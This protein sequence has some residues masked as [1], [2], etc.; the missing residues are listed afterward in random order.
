[1]GRKA[2]SGYHP[3]GCDTLMASAQSIPIISF[4][5]ASWTVP[6]VPVPFSWTVQMMSSSHAG[7]PPPLEQRSLSSMVE[8][9]TAAELVKTKAALFD[10]RGRA[11]EAKERL[12]FT[13]KENV[14]LQ[15]QLE[16]YGFWLED[17]R[18][19]VRVLRQAQKDGR[20]NH[21]AHVR[22][23]FATANMGQKVEKLASDNSVSLTV[24]AQAVAAQ[25]RKMRKLLA[26]LQNSLDEKMSEQ[27]ALKVEHA[28]EVDEL[29]AALARAKTELA[30]KRNETS[31]FRQHASNLEQHIAAHQNSHAEMEKRCAEAEKKLSTYGDKVAILT[32]KHLRSKGIS[33]KL[34]EENKKL[35]EKRD[36]GECCICLE[37]GKLNV[38]VPCGHVACCLGCGVEIAACPICMAPVQAR[39]PLF[40]CV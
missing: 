15:Q 37:E 38:F 28:R 14:K 1:M 4:V 12:D 21:S 9:N 13:K 17:T 2:K 24:L 19:E 35:V 10:A 16:Q 7:A 30:E 36:F 22:S 11:V 32:K 5:P 40:F 33:A 8:D 20:T 6:T 39:A 34:Y 31:L 3:G 18:E 25:H 29:K 23:T 27:Q 26:R